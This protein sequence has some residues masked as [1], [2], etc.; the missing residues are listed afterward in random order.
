MPNVACIPPSHRIVHHTCTPLVASRLHPEGPQTPHPSPPGTIYQL[1]SQESIKRRLLS[2]E[3]GFPRNP[4]LLSR[5]RVR[6]SPRP[7]STGSISALP[8]SAERRG[9]LINILR[10]DQ[11]LGS[12]TAHCWRGL[13]TGFFSPSLFLLSAL[14]LLPESRP[15]PLLPCLRGDSVWVSGLEVSQGS[16]FVRP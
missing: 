2:P 14:F 16:G 8:I 1:L 5:G 7:P 6:R 3:Q 10:N 4:S 12:G 11:A 15:P 9:G 13:K